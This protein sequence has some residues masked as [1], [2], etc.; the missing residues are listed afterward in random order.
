MHAITDGQ[1]LTHLFIYTRNRFDVLQV[2]VMGAL[3]L[4]VMGPLL[5]VG[6]FAAYVAMRRPVSHGRH[7]ARAIRTTLKNSRLRWGIA[8]LVCYLAV[9]VLVSASISGKNGAG[10]YYFIEW[11]LACCALVGVSIGLQ[12]ARWHSIAPLMRVTTALCVG[13]VAFVAAGFGSNEALRFTSGARALDRHRTSEF[14][15]ALK[16]V[17]D[18]PGPVVAYDLTLM[19]KAGKDPSFEPFIMYELLQKG[20]WDPAP[21]ARELSERGYSAFIGE[22]ELD[23]DLNMPPVMK[24]AIV[25]N[26]PIV[27]T[28]GRYRFHLPETGK[29][30]PET[31]SAMRGVPI[32]ELP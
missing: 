10:P 8:S 2:V 22:T 6:A 4:R 7:P 29:D 11:N 14:Q 20:R 19:L 25:A 16:A 30:M 31:G 26:Y 13:G 24:N 32:Q 27:K 9:A 12:L 15:E 28:V 18:L 21:L 5:I 1:F 17:R 3:N 23:Q